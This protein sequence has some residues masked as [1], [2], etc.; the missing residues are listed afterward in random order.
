VS[1]YSTPFE[2]V[3]RLWIIPGALLRV[4][5]PIFTETFI[6]DRTRSLKII[7]WGYISIFLAT[8]PIVLIVSLF[9]REGLGLWLGREF[10]AQSS[11][12]L[13]ILAIGVFIN[14]LGQIP[15]AFIQAS[16]RSDVT[17]KIH[18]VELPFYALFAWLLIKPFVILGA[19]LAWSLRIL[20]DTS[21]LLSFSRRLMAEQRALIIRVVPV[22]GVCV[23][24]FSLGI[25]IGPFAMRVLY[26]A[27]ILLLFMLIS[28]KIVLKQQGIGTLLAWVKISTQG[29]APQI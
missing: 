10:A 8:F 5:F 15:F 26:G 1:Y 20:V 7:R 29:E 14:G 21:V 13:Q 25:I 16:G 9:A 3:T 23:V 19:A 6:T 24:V 11:L 28:R 17:G 22:I 18:L 27:S 2:V 4:L 12:V